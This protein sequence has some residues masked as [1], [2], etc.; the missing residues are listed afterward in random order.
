MTV[1]TVRPRLLCHFVAATAVASLVA[2]G[3]ADKPKS[4]EPT[5]V[6][7]RVNAQDISVHQLDTLLQSQPALASRYGAQAREKV[8]NS[9]IEQELAAQAA[10]RADLDH[11]PQV[12]QALELARRE[13]LARA[14]QDQLAA[15]AVEPSSDEV[16]RF[17]DSR[18]ELFA[19][20]KRFT[21]QDVVV[22]LAGASAAPLRSRI[23]ELTR[24]DDV[25]PALRSAGVRYTSR[26]H[27]RFA[28]EIPAAVLTKIAGL[29]IGHSVWVD[30]EGGAEI[31]SLKAAEPASL[32]LAEARPTIKAYLMQERRRR[33]VDE[34]MQSLRQAAKI[35]Y[36]GEAPRASSAPA[37][38]PASAP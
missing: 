13:V 9:L 8:L 4:S 29:T 17:Y 7:A 37:S 20:R 21:L 28:E 35:E 22:D 31:F 15:K 3:G 23:A 36:V 34:G 24:P 2:C 33:V 11:S 5:Q 18:P 10:K 27:E 25:E 6:A 30:R 32:T 14:Y 12:L 19:Q 26:V 38:A 1:Q 16:D